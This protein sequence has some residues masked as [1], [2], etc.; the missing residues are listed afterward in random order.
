MVERYYDRKAMKKFEE[1]RD[2]VKNQEVDVEQ[3]GKVM[4]ARA[5]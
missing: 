2:R 5:A 4:R 1:I 3:V